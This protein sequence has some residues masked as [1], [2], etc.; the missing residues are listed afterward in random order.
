MICNFLSMFDRTFVRQIG[1]DS[2]C[3]E[4][5][6]T[7]FCLN[8]GLGGAAIDHAEHVVSV[9]SGQSQLAIPIEGSKHW[10]F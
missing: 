8:A 7:D 3:T 1:G 9:D 2:C 6:T 10:P 4:S 5:M